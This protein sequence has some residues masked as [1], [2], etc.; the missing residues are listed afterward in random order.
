MLRIRMQKMKILKIMVRYYIREQIGDK[1]FYI[2]HKD[3]YFVPNLQNFSFDVEILFIH[4]TDK[5]MKANKIG[6]TTLGKTF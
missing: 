1:Y 4:C 3:L 6:K 5:P 2:Y